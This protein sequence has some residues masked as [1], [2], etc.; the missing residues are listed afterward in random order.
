MYDASPP[1]SPVG[2]PAS[3]LGAAGAGRGGGRWR[4][5]NRGRLPCCLR[6]WRLRRLWRWGW[7]GRCRWRRLDVVL[8]RALR[9]GCGLR[10]GWRFC[11]RWRCFC[12]RWRFGGG[13]AAGSAGGSAAGGAASA[14]GGAASA[15]GGAGSAAG[16]AGSAAG[17]SASG[18]SSV[19]DGAVAGWSL[20]LPSSMT[21]SSEPTSTVSSSATVIL[22]RMPATGDGIS[23]STLSVDTSSSGS[24]TA[25]WSPSFFSQRVTV[26]SVTLSPRRGIVTETDMRAATPLHG[27]GENAGGRSVVH[28]KRLTRKSE[29]CLTDRLGLRRVRVDELRDL[30]RQRLPVVDQLGF[31]DQFADARADSV[32]AEDRARR[33]R[34]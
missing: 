11:G 34:R 23:V 4:G 12:G 9:R 13:S 22:L 29:H 31:G 6:G 20:P 5:G 17:G 28:V 27:R 8:A 26:P 30:T 21:A 2:A 16:G 32:N 19:V 1:A 18:C 24:S 15:A 33:P 3:A 7:F 14:A 10:F 25:T